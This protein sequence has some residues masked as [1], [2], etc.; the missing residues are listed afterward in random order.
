[1]SR[2]AHDGSRSVTHQNV[3]GN[4]DRNFFLCKRVYRVFS[5]EYACLFIGGRGSLYVVHVLYLFDIFPDRLLIFSTLYHRKHRRI[6][7]RQNHVSSS[8]DGVYSRGEYG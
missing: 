5:N 1:M 6:F 3:I 8:I 7:R 2:H 4:V